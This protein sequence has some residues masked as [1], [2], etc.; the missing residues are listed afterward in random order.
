MAMPCATCTSD[1]RDAIEA[2]IIANPSISA[3]GRQFGMSRDSLSRHR[4]NHMSPAVRAAIDQRRRANPNDTSVTLLERV[5]AL[6]VDAQDILVDAK[7]QGKPSIALAAIREARGLL[8]TYGRAT[9]ELKPDG[10]VTVQVL[11]VATSPEWQAIR[12]ALFRTFARLE[13][14]DEARVLFADE[15]RSIDGYSEPAPAR[16]G[17]R[18]I[19]PYRAPLD[20]EQ[21][22]DEDDDA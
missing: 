18:A 16:V 3:V 5:L 9:G 17:A 8:D 14:G 10:A 15:M 7:K 22:D 21:E 13:N 4:D 12:D 6:L 2:A 11:N 19:V 20:D 1:E